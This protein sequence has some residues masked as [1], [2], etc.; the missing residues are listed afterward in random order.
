MIV[1]V[2]GGY[3]KVIELRQVSGHGPAHA[4]RRSEHKNRLLDVAAL[5][6]QALPFRP[7]A[8]RSWR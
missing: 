7:P 1:A 4:D 3:L 2:P 6:M 5:R 8:P